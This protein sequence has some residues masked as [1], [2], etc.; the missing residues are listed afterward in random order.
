MINRL[1]K[2]ICLALTLSI[3]AALMVSAAHAM[4]PDLAAQAPH[5]GEC[6]NGNTPDPTTGYCSDPA[7]E[8]VG[9]SVVELNGFSASSNPGP[10]RLLIYIPAITGLSVLILLSVISIRYIQTKRPYDE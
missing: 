5:I 8:T 6:A 2:R 4:V 1:I 10:Y 3:L 9:P 7:H